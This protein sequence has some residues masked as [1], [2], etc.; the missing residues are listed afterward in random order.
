MSYRPWWWPLIKKTTVNHRTVKFPTNTIKK[1]TVNTRTVKFPIAEFCFIFSIAWRGWC[2]QP[3]VVVWCCPC[4]SFDG[5]LQAKQ[6]P[7]LEEIKSNSEIQDDA[8]T[9]VTG[10]TTTGTAD[11]KRQQC[12]QAN[13]PGAVMEQWEIHKLEWQSSFK[14]FCS[15]TVC[16]GDDNLKW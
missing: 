13:V 10:T 9:T 14:K 3:T 15:V 7:H 6:P 12:G 1:T 4:P 2:N 11:R 5:T 8:A 16:H